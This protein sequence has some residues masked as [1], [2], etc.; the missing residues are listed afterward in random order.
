MGFLFPFSHTFSSPHSHN[1]LS[2]SSLRR[3]SRCHEQLSLVVSA[4]HVKAPRTRLL[5][6]STTYPPPRVGSTST[7]TRPRCLLQSGA[8]T[9]YV[10]R[11]KPALWVL[12]ISRWWS[13]PTALATSS[14][15]TPVRITSY[16]CQANPD[17]TS[18]P[19]PR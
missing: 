12:A 3:T 9:S 8:P 11:T 5:P 1:H 7:R 16:P 14:W 6:P 19:S 10:A 15:P 17:P 2:S 13:V 4:W 18:T